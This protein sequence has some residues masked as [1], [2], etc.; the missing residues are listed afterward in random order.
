MTI[1]EYVYIGTTL[2]HRIGNVNLELIKI[3]PYHKVESIQLQ[4]I[5]A[6]GENH[7]IS[8]MRQHCFSLFSN[9]QPSFVHQMFWQATMNLYVVQLHDKSEIKSSW[10]Y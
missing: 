3:V 7:V 1:S 4:W 8:T 6:L 9:I 2:H 5:K 10:E